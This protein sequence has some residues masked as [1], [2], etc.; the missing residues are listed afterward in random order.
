MAA[1]ALSFCA[2]GASASTRA[3]LFARWPI[4][5]IRAAMLEPSTVL[6]GAAMAK[7]MF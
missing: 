6:S 1:S 2:V 4:S 7:S 3:A 5:C